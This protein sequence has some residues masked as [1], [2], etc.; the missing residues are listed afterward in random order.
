M[1]AF[2]PLSNHQSRP[3]DSDAI[4]LGSNSLVTV[5]VGTLNSGVSRGSQGS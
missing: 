1:W 4:V 2:P 3:Q 5:L